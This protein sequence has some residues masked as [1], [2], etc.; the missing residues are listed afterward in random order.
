VTT[1]RTQVLDMMA[2]EPK[3]RARGRGNAIGKPRIA[4]VAE[5]ST[6]MGP[7]ETETYRRDWRAAYQYRRHVEKIAG[8]RAQD[9]ILAKLE[10]DAVAAAEKALR[11]A[12]GTK[13]KTAKSGFAAIREA[14][15]RHEEED[16]DHAPA[17]S[18]NRKTLAPVVAAT[19]AARLMFARLSEENEVDVL[20]HVARHFQEA[21]L[22]F[23]RD[24]SPLRPAVHGE[25]QRLGQRSQPLYV[26][27]D[28]ETRAGRRRRRDP[29]RRTG[30]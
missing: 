26:A 11:A 18:G 25:L 27:L 21:T 15:R 8:E 20:D 29:R 24:E 14:A 6:A 16:F 28:A 22:V 10:K 5:G 17:S 7:V 4:A 9:L 13:G 19:V 30:C 12:G 1:E 23:A 2:K 3:P